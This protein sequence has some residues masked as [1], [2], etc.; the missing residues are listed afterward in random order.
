M[1][2]LTGPTG[3]PESDAGGQRELGVDA[4]VD[5]AGDDSETVT[6][7]VL[8]EVLPGVA[9]AF[10][11]VPEELD[12]VDLGFMSDSDRRQL[13]VALAPLVG[14]SATVAGNVGNA[15][16]AAKGVYVVDAATQSLLNSGAVL[17]VKDGANLGSVWLEGKLI[18]QARFIS[19]SAVST[20]Q[21]AAS[22]GPAVAMIGLQVQL[23]Q[24]TGLVNTNIALTSQV[25]TENRHSQWA[26]LTGLTK[27]INTALDRA[28][29]I[30][31]VPTSLWDTIAG[32]EAAL[33]KQLDLYR[34]NVARHA[35]Q[36]EQLGTHPRREYLEANADAV[37]FD[38]YALL[39][40]LKTWTAYQA[41]HAGKARAAGPE[42]PDEA[43]LVDIIVRD[44]Q[45]EFEAAL[46]EIRSLVDSLR[47]ELGIIAAL[48]VRATVPLTRK[49]KDR[50]ASGR[51][52]TRLLEAMEPLATALRLEAPALRTPE[53]VAAPISLE[54][55][56]YLGIL[57]WTLQNG[58]KLRGLAFPYQLNGID[59]VRTVGPK[60][61]PMAVDS[62]VRAVKGGGRE[63]AKWAEAI[64]KAAASTLVALTDRRV[65]LAEANAFTQ[66]GEIGRSIPLDHIRYVRLVTAS[67]A[68][69]RSAIDLI[70][71][72]ENIQWL[73]HSDA[74]DGHVAAIAALLAESMA[75]PQEE[76]DALL[77]RH[78]PAA[79]PTQ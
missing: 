31:S 27:A 30:R 28:R 21:L 16:A 24:L 56:P 34:R 51:T 13:A 55:A 74:E 12:L 59:L 8:A 23:N 4:H 25:L 10:G 54:L 2:N 77:L 39:T 65:V 15:L 6:S 11:D 14:N 60:V 35:T 75:V 67:D 66:R 20:A 47:R 52:S 3:I 40:S 26:E 5:A 53:V 29:E 68:N 7:L 50:A 70:T 37:L 48:P 17:A 45:L 79:L 61:V 57:R 43:Q 63:H 36:L 58:E 41:L 38:A 73:F 49:R 71:R 78:S 46:A 72:D 44:T 69:E 33:R 1:P 18:A 9:V 42:E 22:I 62:V 76:R 19:V 64:D 32:R